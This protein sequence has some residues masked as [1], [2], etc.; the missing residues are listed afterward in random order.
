MSTTRLWQKQLARRSTESC[1]GTDT[2]LRTAG[3]GKKDIWVERVNVR[4]RGRLRSERK[5]DDHILKD[6]VS[7]GKVDISPTRKMGGLLQEDG[8]WTEQLADV[9][10]YFLPRAL[11]WTSQ[12][13]ESVP[14]SRA[15]E[16]RRWSS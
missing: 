5:T 14:D 8:F 16:R 7:C 3:G 13:K 15:F 6:G 12:A 10:R 1:V 4:L 2:S 11:K 9:D